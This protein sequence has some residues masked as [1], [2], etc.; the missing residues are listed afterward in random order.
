MTISLLLLAASFS[1]AASKDLSPAAAFSAM[2]SWF[3]P[4]QGQC[5]PSVRF[6]SRGAR[7]TVLVEDR[8]AT[9][10]SGS[11]FLRLRMAD[12][13]PARINAVKPLA[14]KSF[15]LQGNR[16]SQWKGAVQHFEAVRAEGVYAGIDALYYVR[17]RLLEFDL[18]LA[19]EADPNR[20]RLR[21]EGAG[22]MTLSPDGDLLLG[23][24]GAE[25]WLKRPFAYQEEA[26]KRTPVAA[27]YRLDSGEIRF[28]LGPY[29]RTRTLVIDPVF[30]AGY[31]G[32]DQDGAAR[33]VV[34]DD[35]GNVWVAGYSRAGIPQPSRP[36]PVQ[37]INRGGRDAFLAKFTRNETGGLTL[38]FWTLFGGSQDDVA[39]HVTFDANGFVYIAG[40]TSSPDYPLLGTQVQQTHAGETDGFVT[41]LRPDDPGGEI[42][43]YSALYGG[44]K[45]D[46][47]NAV[48]VDRTGTIHIA[49]YTT[50]GELPGTE[51]ALQCCNRGGFEGFMAKIDPS[52]SPSLVYSTFFGG[53]GTDVITGMAVDESFN[54]YLAGYTGAEDFPIT[55]E[56][57]RAHSKSVD[58]FVAK[59]DVRRPG[60]DAL[61]FATTVGGN[62]LDV[63]HAMA[64]DN[65]GHVWLAGYTLSTDLPLTETAHRRTPAG[66]ADAFVMK[67]DLNAA[68]Q[69]RVLYASLLGGRATDICYG[70]S[71]AAGGR[72]A[73][74]G[75]T[76]SD[77]FP[78]LDSEAGTRP[79][80]G[81]ADAFV[82]V[83][84]P[85]ISGPEALTFSRVLGGTLTDV[86][87]GVA[88]DPAGRL[89]LAGSTSSFDLSTTD[90]S[91]KIAPPGTTQGF[92][93]MAAPPAGR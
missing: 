29:D 55:V 6:F 93:L 2:P 47:V 64:L 53:N 48:A 38:A 90:G 30:H 25:L 19:P 1:L 3:E 43:W 10:I 81:T 86:A 34:V 82:T 23:D 37:A 14:S 57:P 12:S 26:G 72:I 39:N 58:L 78:I 85:R 16:K 68:P 5:D 44:P 84:D 22:R 45:A 91:T 77:D 75:Y 63:A 28:E 32:G 11:Q 49:G 31:L 67:L 83:L 33:S 15:Y 50:S 80:A 35:L 69:N 46:F 17:D 71:L 88:S 87:H 89:F 18:I 8:G 65:N 27:R 7:G 59:L 24:A 66:Q 51:A 21:L 73:L 62:G 54:V 4:N 20:I 70:L 41:V 52:R 56:S 13:S 76:F 9:F 92:V 40:Y 36:E 42:A 61:V 60:L 79:V 74:A